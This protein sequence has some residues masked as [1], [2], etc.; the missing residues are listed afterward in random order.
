MINWLKSRGGGG[1]GA[2]AVLPDGIKFTGTGATDMNWL[3]DVDTSR[4]T[5]MESMCF[6][7][8]NITSVGLFDT[9]NVV[10]VTSAFRGCTKLK[11]VP[12]FDLSNVNNWAFSDM[13]NSCPNLSDDS[14]NNIMGMFLTTTKVSGGSM[15]LKTI[16]LTQTQAEKC[17]T[18]S[19]WDAFA[20]AGWSTGY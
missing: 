6:S 15:K 9:S 4:L 8:S 20:A 19:N 5:T 1:S 7:M 14:L 16:G 13:F 18:L 3:S 12:V 10:R 11:D 2:K 17:M